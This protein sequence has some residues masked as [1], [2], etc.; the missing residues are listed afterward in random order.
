MEHIELGSVG[1][2]GFG[3]WWSGEA[4]GGVD[5]EG[6]VGALGSKVAGFGHLD[7]VHEERFG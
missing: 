2:G 6:V 1:D 7:G 3:I 4:L 5:G